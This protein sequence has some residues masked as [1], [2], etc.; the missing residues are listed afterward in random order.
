MSI[1]RTAWCRDEQGDITENASPVSQDV[2]RAAT[3]SSEPIL[4]SKNHLP[5]TSHA[6]LQSKSYAACDNPLYESNGTELGGN[7][8]N[9]PEQALV[10][11]LLQCHIPVY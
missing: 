9:H 6:L 10:R 2:R 11:L 7:K 1:P 5:D 3:A 4:T 8:E